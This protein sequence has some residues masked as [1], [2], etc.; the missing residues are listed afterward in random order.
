MTT[1]LL[2]AALITSDAG[3]ADDIEAAAHA[4]CVTQ[5]NVLKHSLGRP[6][7]PERETLVNHNRMMLETCLANRRKHIEKERR[8]RQADEE[9]RVQAEQREQAEAR[10]RERKENDPVYQR[11]AIS[12]LLCGAI[13]RK[14]CAL[15]AIAA[16]KKLAKRAGVVNLRV[17]QDNKEILKEAED[18]IRENQREL[19]ARHLKALACKPAECEE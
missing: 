7:G 19:K 14:R 5:E 12:E 8:E 9:N 3:A 16:E 4:G 15:A 11:E 17:L 6:P 13:W 18:E 10:E 1:L 2:V